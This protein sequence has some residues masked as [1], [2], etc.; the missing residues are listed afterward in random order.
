LQLP[1]PSQTIVYAVYMA[2]P[3]LEFFDVR[4]LVVHSGELIAWWAWGVATLYALAYSSFFLF[5]AWLMFR[6]KAL[7]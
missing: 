7:N 6:R 3:H 5:L 4:D 1:V 2:I